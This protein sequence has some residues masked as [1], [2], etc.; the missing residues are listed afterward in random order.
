[1]RFPTIFGM[2]DQQR[3]RPACTYAQADQSRCLS[4]NYSMRVKLLIKLHLEFLSSKGSCTCSSEST[5]SLV[6]MP[7]C[8]K[9]HVTA[10]IVFANPLKQ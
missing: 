5:L 2:C 1:M 7:H 3:L 6:E 8:W 4:F 10:Q 9:S